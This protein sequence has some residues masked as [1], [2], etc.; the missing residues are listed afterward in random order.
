MKLH[1]R[2]R[3][4]VG[5]ESG[6]LECQVPTGRKGSACCASL[7]CAEGRLGTEGHSSQA[8]MKTHLPLQVNP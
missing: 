1:L 7:D 4:A 3:H 2:R 8:G 5:L 6:C